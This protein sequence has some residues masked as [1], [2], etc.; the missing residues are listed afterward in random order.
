[1]IVERQSFFYFFL[2]IL[3]Y[4]LATKP[5]NKNGKILQKNG[6]D[7]SRLEPRRARATIYSC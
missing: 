4:F 5:W 3:G 2:K 1:M 7:A 6:R